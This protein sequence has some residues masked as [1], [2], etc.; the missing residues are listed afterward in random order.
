LVNSVGSTA[1]LHDEEGGAVAT[2]EGGSRPNVPKRE[3]EVNRVDMTHKYLKEV[4]PL[5]VAEFTEIFGE[6]VLEA[7]KKKDLVTF[8][9]VDGVEYVYPK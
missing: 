2:A 3:G 4:G 7:L 9:V 1:E 6:D 8:N 5:S